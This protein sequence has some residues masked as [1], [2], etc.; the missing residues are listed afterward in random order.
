VYTRSL[1]RDP[2]SMMERPVLVLWSKPLPL[3]TEVQKTTRG[4]ALPETIS[5]PRSGGAGRAGSARAAWRRHTSPWP[6]TLRSSLLHQSGPKPLSLSLSHR[7]ALLARPVSTDR[8]AR[9]RG[10][11]PAATT[12]RQPGQPPALRAVPR[13]PQERVVVR[14]VC[15]AG[16]PRVAYLLPFS[17]GLLRQRSGRDC[18]GHPHR[19]RLDPPSI[20]R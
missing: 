3:W 11:I 18:R 6:V 1:D 4:S 2:I 10:V 8:T 17:R 15:L 13:L 9:V 12:L 5:P 19:S 16:W 20:R 7:Y 14:P